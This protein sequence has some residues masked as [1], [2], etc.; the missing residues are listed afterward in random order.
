M[1]PMAVSELKAVSCHSHSVSGSKQGHFFKLHWKGVI[2]KSV[3]LTCLHLF[4]VFLHVTCWSCFMTASFTIIQLINAEFNLRWNFCISTM[5]PGEKQPCFYSHLFRVRPGIVWPWPQLYANII[6]IFS[7]PFFSLS[8]QGPI[9][10][11]YENIIDCRLDRTV[12][13]QRATPEIVYGFT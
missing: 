10:E 6:S 1:P 2:Y 9:C 8:P 7:L 3:L 13:T 4:F 11:A 12:L 5:S